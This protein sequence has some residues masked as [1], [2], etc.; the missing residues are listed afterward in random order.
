MRVVREQ[1]S[2]LDGI[3]A[4]I[5]YKNIKNLY[6]R[7]RDGYIEL[8]VP[9]RTAWRDMENFVSRRRAWI[10]ER[11]RLLSARAEKYA[12]RYVDGE[13]IQLWGAE[14]PLVCVPLTQGKP[15]AEYADGVIVLHVSEE[16]G[17][18]VRRAVIETLYRAELAAAI[19]RE[20]PVCEAT[21]GKRAALW[22]IRAMKTRWGSCNVRTAVVTLNLELARYDVRALR[23]VITHEL[24]HLWVRGHNAQFYAHM[25]RYF[26]GWQDVRRELNAWVRAENSTI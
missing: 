6:L 23:Y 4:Q 18:D 7:V 8:S 26:P 16:A 5:R 20:A 3:P 19:E 17:V 11:L 10:E 13:Q 1:S 9:Q 14:Y 15:H 2:V 21:V 25:D 12:P 22:R 24:T